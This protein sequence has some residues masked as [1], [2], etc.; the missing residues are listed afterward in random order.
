MVLAPY[1]VNQDK[2]SGKTSDASF[3]YNFKTKQ[4]TSKQAPPF[5]T[6]VE[7]CEVL[8]DSVKAL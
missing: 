3:E 2:L 8:N 5:G 7:K 6:I 4:Y 1:K